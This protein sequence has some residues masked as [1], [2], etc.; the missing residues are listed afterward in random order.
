MG[1]CFEQGIL[2]IDI[3]HSLRVAKTRAVC[4]SSIYVALILLSGRP[5]SC[6]VECRV[7]TENAFLSVG[8]CAGL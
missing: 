4:V 5:N 1:R 3:P 6:E 7:A 2:T 8:F